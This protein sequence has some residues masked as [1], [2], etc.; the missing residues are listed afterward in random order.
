MSVCVSRFAVSTTCPSSGG[1]LGAR[2]EVASVRIAPSV[3]SSVARRG[4][5][6]ERRAGPRA[7]PRARRW[8]AALPRRTGTRRAVVFMAPSERDLGGHLRLGRRREV[9]ALL[10][11]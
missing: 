6:R 4:Q 10:E 5:T 11:G 2:A 3:T 9:H 7:A 1:G 8:E